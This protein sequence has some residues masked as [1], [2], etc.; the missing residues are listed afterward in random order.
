MYN[1]IELFLAL[2]GQGDEVVSQSLNLFLS[3]SSMWSQIQYMFLMFG[4][5]DANAEFNCD[6]MDYLYGEK[7]KLRYS[8]IAPLRNRVRFENI[9]TGMFLVICDDVEIMV[10]AFRLM[11]SLGLNKVLDG[12]ILEAESA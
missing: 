7:I 10:P 4:T 11:A 2:N 8:K 3:W 5:E 9:H 12:R 1:C 6:S